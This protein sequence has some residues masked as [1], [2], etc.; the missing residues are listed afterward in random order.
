[1]IKTVKRQKGF[2]L[3]EVLI[4]TLLVTAA[5]GLLLQ[6]F[7]SAAIRTHKAAGHA[8]II[9]AQ[10]QIYQ[11]ISALNIHNVKKGK[12]NIENINYQWQAKQQTKYYPLYDNDELMTKIT[13]Y[14]VNVELQL[15]DGKKRK[16]QWEQLAWD[17]N[18]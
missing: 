17:R 8:R 1:M 4:A 9:L 15:K 14:L 5:L 10:K 11:Q 18:F 13:R 3:I 6:L 16:F 12:G 7:A 2:T